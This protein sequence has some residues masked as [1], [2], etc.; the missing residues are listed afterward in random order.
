MGKMAEGEHTLQTAERSRAYMQ[1]AELDAQEREIADLPMRE[2]LKATAQPPSC[3][4]PTRPK[5]FAV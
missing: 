4:A 3:Y 1:V 5:H 2:A